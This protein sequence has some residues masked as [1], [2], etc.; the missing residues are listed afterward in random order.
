[1]KLP[2]LALSY[3]LPHAAARLFAFPALVACA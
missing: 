3:G 2:A 1:M